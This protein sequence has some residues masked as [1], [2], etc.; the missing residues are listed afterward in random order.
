MMGI[1]ASL[2]A[3]NHVNLAQMLHGE[4][5]IELKKPLPTSGSNEAFC[6]K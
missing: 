6:L 5:Y 1:M 3:F 2:P 4:Q